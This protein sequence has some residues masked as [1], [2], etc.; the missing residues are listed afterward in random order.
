M[1]SSTTPA[2][3]TEIVT[4]WR[5]SAGSGL[6]PDA[7]P[8]MVVDEDLGNCDRLLRVA[9][10]IL[11]HAGDQLTDTGVALLLTDSESRLISRVFGGTTVERH[12][13]RLGA[14]HG[15]F[16][17]EDAV[18]T[19]GLGTPVEIRK[20]IAVNGDEH[21]LERFKHLSCYGYPILHPGTNRLEG[22][23]CMTSVS[24]TIHP[25]F[26]PFVHRI[27]TDIQSS[28]L[29]HARSSH[30]LLLD[31]F[32][33]IGKRSIAAVAI[34]DDLLLTNNTA[35]ALLDPID[36]AVL[37]S[38]ADSTETIPPTLT[39]S[40][41]ATV[42]VAV[43]RVAGPG[44]AVFALTPETAHRPSI[45]RRTVHEE[46]SAT[47]VFTT[48]RFVA[49]AGRS[50]AITGEPGTGRSVLARSATEGCTVE[51]VDVAR[52]VA[53]GSPVDIAGAAQRARH[54]GA[55]LV[56]DDVDLL[57]ATDTTTLRRLLI[58]KDPPIVIVAG[59]GDSV[60]GAVAALCALCDE[61]TDLAPLR[62]RTQ[63][64]AAAAA[65]FVDRHAPGT[66]IR[67]R[68]ID[69]LA[70]HVWPANY[71]ELGHVIA[72]AASQARNQG[73][74]HTIDVE[75]LPAHLREAGRAARLSMHERVERQG[76][77]DALAE[78]RNNKVHAARRLGISRST[79]YARIRALGIDT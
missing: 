31:A 71:T 22:I 54:T 30:Q 60:S 76:I 13:D 68:V 65:F 1:R 58:D 36:L 5:R 53:T 51:L 38:F 8:D 33:R 26:A 50:L 72:D 34:G 69:A 17:N 78:C 46:P 55:V 67:P 61:R 47:H 57:S 39:L 18:G 20:P 40:S 63:H 29:D 32:H 37:R 10:P 3:R 28:L 45:P 79:L 9:R 77:I 59:A 70:A 7:T 56:V 4:S 25:L 62:H 11:D 73:R 74:S 23:L 66:H 24:D 52:A 75:D 44:S 41:G 19:T 49:A 6:A 42:D 64:I 2:L 16:M 15:S 35:G 43:E 48:S 12:I 21:Y 27:A 14:V